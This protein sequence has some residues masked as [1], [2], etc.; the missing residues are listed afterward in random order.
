MVKIGD[1]YLRKKNSKAISMCII[2]YY[3]YHLKTIFKLHSFAQ[4]YRVNS[5]DAYTNTHY[6]CKIY[7]CVCVCIIYRGIL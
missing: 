4:R 2:Q 1:I 7:T 3:K 5:I 6:L